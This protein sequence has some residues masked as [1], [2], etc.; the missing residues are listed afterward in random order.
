MQIIKTIYKGWKQLNSEMAGGWYKESP[1]T[2]VSI[3]HDS[4][5]YNIAFAVGV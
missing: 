5:A 3:R 2:D 4:I 1:A